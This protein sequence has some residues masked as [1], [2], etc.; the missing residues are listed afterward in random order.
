MPEAVAKAKEAV[1]SSAPGVIAAALPAKERDRLQVNPPP[2]PFKL[3]RRFWV[4]K[5]SF[6]GGVTARPFVVI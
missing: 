6:L 5:A 4:E 3:H 2:P 1:R